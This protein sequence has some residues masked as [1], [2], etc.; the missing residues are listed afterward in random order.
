MLQVVTDS[1]CDL[2]REFIEEHNVRVVPLTVTI[3]DEVFRE[4]VDLTSEEFYDRMAHSADLP[5]TSQPSPAVFAE[6]FRELSQAGPIICITISSGLSGTYQ[7]ACLG[8]ELSEADV[9]VFDSLIGSL[10]HGLQVLKAC[11]LASAGYGVDDAIAELTRYRDEME[12]L[13]LLNTLENIVKGGRLSRF[14]GSISKI[15]DIRVILHDEDGEVVLREKV[16]GKK[17]FMEHILQT[18][19]ALRPDMT[20]RTVGITHFRNPADVETIQRALRDTC[21]PEG[22]IVNDM[23]P[24][25][26]TYASEGGMIVVF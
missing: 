9:T 3:D 11:E 4:G 1:S 24:T 14:Q 7:S 10:G 17:K 12:G 20:G 18:I 8:A 19:Y 6:V 26:A 25:M 22:F 23:G 15:L 5:K 2:P 21:H 16:R 13:V